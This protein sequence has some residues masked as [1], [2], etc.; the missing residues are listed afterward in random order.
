LHSSDVL[1]FSFAAGLSWKDEKFW[2]SVC[3]FSFTTY[4]I[5][6]QL[7]RSHKPLRVGS[8]SSDPQKLLYLPN[9]VKDSSAHVPNI[10][11]TSQV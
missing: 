2:L 7:R 9:A 5:T 1:Y 4:E 6:S 11:H 3:C 10:L 8:T